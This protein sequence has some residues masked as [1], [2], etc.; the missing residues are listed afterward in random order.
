MARALARLGTGRNY[1]Q[2]AS[3]EAVYLYQLSAA[4][5][6]GVFE[7]F[8]ADAQALNGWLLSVRAG[9]GLVEDAWAAFIAEGRDASRSGASDLGALNKAS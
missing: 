7:P 1:A 4:R 2:A 9:K 8:D 6:H 3:P 5:K